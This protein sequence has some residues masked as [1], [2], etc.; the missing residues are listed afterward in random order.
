VER[1]HHDYH[2]INAY[3]IKK[4]G[5]KNNIKSIYKLKSEKIYSI[6]PFEIESFLNDMA[7]DYRD[8]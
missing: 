1:L 3:A 7:L 2:L 5:L 6:Y 4:Y 8:D